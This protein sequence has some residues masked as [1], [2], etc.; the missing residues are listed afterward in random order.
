MFEDLH[1]GHLALMLET[2]ENHLC[3]ITKYVF[4]MLEVISLFGSRAIV[5]KC[6]CEF[7]KSF[8]CSLGN[9]LELVMR[10]RIILEMVGCCLHLLENFLYAQQATD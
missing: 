9:H 3:V 5:E 2:C 10:V 4:W 7:K 6:R 1:I 8:L